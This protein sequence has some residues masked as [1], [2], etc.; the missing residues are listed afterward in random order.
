MEFEAIYHRH[1][2]SKPASSGPSN[3][4]PTFHSLGPFSGP[5]STVNRQT[6]GPLT[7]PMDNT[8]EVD[9]SSRPRLTQE[10]ITILEQEFAKLPKPSTDFKK[11]LADRIGL[12]L[13]RVNVSCTPYFFLFLSDQSPQNW[14]QNRRAKTKN[15]AKTAEA[16]FEVRTE[17]LQLIWPTTNQ[18]FQA[19]P[20]YFDT[21]GSSSQPQSFVNAIPAANQDQNLASY[22]DGGQFDFDFDP[23]QTEMPEVVPASNHDTSSLAF[24][25][26]DFNSK[27]CPP[28]ISVLSANY[29]MPVTETVDY[30]LEVYSPDTTVGFAIPQDSPAE[31]TME[32]MYSMVEN[33]FHVGN[34]SNQTF[35]SAASSSD[36]EQ[37]S[38]M[39]PP[40]RNSPISLQPQDGFDRRPS[41]TGALTNEFQNSFHLKR[42]KSGQAV[43]EQSLHCPGARLMS[44]A[45]ESP[46]VTPTRWNG[47]SLPPTLSLDVS[48][49][50]G[51]ASN[52][53][54][55]AARRKRPRP[56]PLIKPEAQ[57]S[58]S[59]TGPLTSSPPSARKSLLKPTQPVRRIRSNLD[60]FSGR[61]QK[62][63]S[64][65]AHQS[66]RNA[67][68][69][70][71]NAITPDQSSCALTNTQAPPTPLSALHANNDSFGYASQLDTHSHQGLATPTT[72]HDSFNLNSPPVTPYDVSPLSMERSQGVFLGRAFEAH[73]PPQSAPPQK[74]SFF[75]GDSP[76]MANSNLGHLSWQ[77]PHEVPSNHFPDQ[78]AAVVVQPQYHAITGHFEQPPVPSTFAQQQVYRSPPQ[79][80]VPSQPFHQPSF[81]PSPEQLFQQS[82]QLAFP[83]YQSPPMALYHHNVYELQTQPQPL[84]IKVE[85]GPQ[86]KGPVQPRKQYTFSNSTPD[87]FSSSK[88]ES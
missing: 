19:M 84:E 75:S 68:S 67:E 53:I 23:I 48:T 87:D 28:G 51:S 80:R 2:R 54:D 41:I 85:L 32:T 62:P 27:S 37:P 24:G 22:F 3:A 43:L 11:Q 63:R 35:M 57:R 64:A 1:N 5:M 56:A 21:R 4:I 59:Y 38:M 36:G 46:S 9:T 71:Q 16:Q 45:H 65:S 77:A 39:T 83:Q 12:T 66:P 17:D 13:A 61:V 60:V 79:H 49:E 70:F 82:H 8:E 58:C 44:P 33:G 76:P 20:S 74:T 25:S 14:Y 72:F 31:Q 6:S 50:N 40:E 47:G 7:S 10:Q 81:Q 30:G 52:R 34:L 15:G 86:P 78:S 42:Q 55:I 29:K 18:S 88:D 26:L 69:R 73:Q